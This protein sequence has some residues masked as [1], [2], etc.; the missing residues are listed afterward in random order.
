MLQAIRGELEIALCRYDHQLRCGPSARLRR[1][2]NRHGRILCFR[3][4]I[5]DLVIISS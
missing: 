2:L 3:L 5:F 4:T 1:S